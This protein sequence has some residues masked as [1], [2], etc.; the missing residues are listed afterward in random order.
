MMEGSRF[1]HSRFER[2]AGREMIGIEATR[3]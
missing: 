2:E 3:E 1:E